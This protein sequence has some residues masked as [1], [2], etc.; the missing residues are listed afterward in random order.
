[1]T[2]RILE[3]SADEMRRL[4]DAALDCVIRHYQG[5]DA[6]PL[7]SR[8]GKSEMDALLGEDLPRQGS[9][10]EELI[11]I[12][13]TRIFRHVLQVSHPRFFGFIPA[14]IPITA[15]LAGLLAEAH[16][17]FNGNWFGG[18]GPAQVEVV[19]LDWLK[20]LMG[21]SPD[22]GGI[23]VSG[24]TE[25]NLLGLVLARENCLHGPLEK[26]TVYCSDQ[27]HFSVRKALMVAGIPR[28]NVRQIA[29]DDNYRL[30][31]ELLLNAVIEDRR[32]GFHPFAIVANAGTTSTG[33]IDPIAGLRRVADDEGL[34]LH[35]DG[36]LGAAGAMTP[37]GR[38]FLGEVGLFDSISID[39]HKW[40]F[41]PFGVGGLFVREPSLMT[42]T[43][44]E[45]AEYIR[46]TQSS[47]DEVNFAEM[48][49]Q[50]TRPFSSLRLWMTF[51]YF[52]TDRIVQAMERP[53]E[54][55]AA[56]EAWLEE[57]DNW[58]IMSG[59]SLGIIC[60]R[61]RDE[62]WSDQVADKFN[63]ALVGEIRRDNT[64][65]MSST[66][67]KGRVCQRICAIN[68]RT[69]VDDVAYALDR[70]NGLASDLREDR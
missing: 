39:P 59:P 15:P 23:L 10:F 58:Q 51:K 55:A 31:P 11:E 45:T 44:G 34:W 4:G 43:F 37:T 12:V 41:Q 46:D 21:F 64:F 9:D 60:F 6:K 20:Q 1:M 36:A 61:Y 42:Q 57:H 24:G 7:H 66:V 29:V 13:E 54:L 69:S 30:D 65:F 3:L 22:A 49:L 16:N 19:V 35:I 38:A 56:A 50:L 70:L 47:G 28:G 67:L 33:A 68:W 27:T 25:A 5:L 40:M 14:P 48:G 8:P 63:Q 62:A 17:A 26:G 2:E 32:D 52:G 18:A 53:F